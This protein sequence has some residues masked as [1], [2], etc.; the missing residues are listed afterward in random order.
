M[1]ISRGVCNLPATDVKKDLTTAQT[2]RIKK[3]FD[4]SAPRNA[5]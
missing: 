2:Q 3:A 5:Q 1:G 4:D